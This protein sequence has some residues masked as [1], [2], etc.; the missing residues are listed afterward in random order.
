MKSSSP[1]N[2]PGKIVAQFNVPSA[3]AFEAYR[4][5]VSEMLGD[6][7]SVKMPP[8]SGGYDGSF[9]SVCVRKAVGGDLTLEEQGVL[10]DCFKQVFEP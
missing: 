4:N 6:G 2:P 10:D 1:Q 7:F 3:E 9:G 5:A 8:F